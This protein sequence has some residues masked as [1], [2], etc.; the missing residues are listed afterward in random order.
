M[1]RV[2]KTEHQTQAL[3]LEV[4]LRCCIDSH[5]TDAELT[6]TQEADLKS[7][8]GHAVGLVVQAAYMHRFGYDVDENNII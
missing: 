4:L 8:I 3:R 5:I 2:L 7:D 6:E 1:P